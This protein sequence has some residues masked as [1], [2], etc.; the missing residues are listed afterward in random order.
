MVSW[1]GLVS[2]DSSIMSSTF[3]V[4]LLMFNMTARQHQ[5]ADMLPLQEYNLPSP[6]CMLGYA[7]ALTTRPLPW[8]ETSRKSE[9]TSA[10]FNKNS[11][12]AAVQ[13]RILNQYV[14]VI[15]EH[16]THQ[17]RPLAGAKWLRGAEKDSPV[18]TS[19]GKHVGMATLP[20]RLSLWSPRDTRR[21]SAAWVTDGTV[22]D[23]RWY[24]HEVCQCVCSL[25]VWTQREKLP[26]EGSTSLD[27]L[28]K[29]P[30]GGTEKKN[31]KDPF[32]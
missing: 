19:C 15:P 21:T 13:S 10:P 16:W 32:F 12:R 3:P 1:W 27:L 29:P 18:L 7:A 8:I 25:I 9:W 28:L 24:Y 30:V 31:I 4:M 2:K 23:S 20:A 6:N 22:W 17:T 11:C 14:C 5:D 26:H